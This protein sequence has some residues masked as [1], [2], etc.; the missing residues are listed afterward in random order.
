MVMM[1]SGVNMM[2]MVRRGCRGC[3]V[4][5]GRIESIDGGLGLGLSDGDIGIWGMCVIMGVMV[6]T[7]RVST[8]MRNGNWS[9]LRMCVR[10]VM[11][12]A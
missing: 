7:L 6:M 5:K 10:Q 11:V 2:V 3:T 1:V 12:M 8:Q 4:W 9:Y